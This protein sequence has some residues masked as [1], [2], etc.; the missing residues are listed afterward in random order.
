[1]S[2][3]SPMKKF[4]PLNSF[5]LNDT[6]P[7]DISAECLAKGALEEAH[8]LT[9]VLSLAITETVGAGTKDTPF[10]TDH[11]AK[12]IDAIGTLIALS[13]FAREQAVQS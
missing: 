1:M 8:A 13:A 6:L 11:V 2:V 5:K 7:F 4:E 12:A 10:Q 3:I 9:V